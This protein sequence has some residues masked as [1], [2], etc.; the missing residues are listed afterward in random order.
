MISS[1]NSDLAPSGLEHTFEDA[2][3]ASASQS[4][5][6][7]SYFV[8][9][10]WIRGFKSTPAHHISCR[11]LSSEVQSKGCNAAL[12]RIGAPL[13]HYHKEDGSVEDQA[14]YVMARTNRQRLE[15]T[16]AA[17]AC[18]PAICLLVTDNSQLLIALTLHASA[19]L[20]G[21]L[22]CCMWQEQYCYCA[23]HAMFCEKLCKAPC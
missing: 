22:Q 20:T 14:V 10:Q 8:T 1:S 17:F 19:V 6:M 11:K 4:C 21:P 13:H 9:F 12:H 15:V 2:H 7:S 3:K 23:A 18:S 5:L 16:S